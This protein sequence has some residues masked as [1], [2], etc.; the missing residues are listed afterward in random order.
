MQVAAVVLRDESCVEWWLLTSGG[1]PL[2][3]RSLDRLTERTEPRFVLEDALV[4][5]GT[6]ALALIGMRTVQRVCD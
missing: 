6:D 4:A 3:Q 2:L 1:T 5:H